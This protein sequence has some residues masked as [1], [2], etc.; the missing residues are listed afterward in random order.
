[1]RS[2]S[3]L[4][5]VFLLV[6]IFF[7]T[8][9]SGDSQNTPQAPTE[10][11]NKPTQTPQAITDPT[12]TSRPE[13]PAT[14]TRLPEPSATPQPTDDQF[15]IKHQNS[16]QIARLAVFGGPAVGKISAATWSE[17]GSWLYVTGS[18]GGAIHEAGTLELLRILPD[19]EYFSFLNDGGTYVFASSG[20]LNF[21]DTSSGENQ[22]EIDLPNFEGELSLVSPLGNFI[23]TRKLPNQ[24]AIWDL[25]GS[26][27]VQEVDLGEFL[28]MDV[29]QLVS[30][31]FSQDGAHLFVATNAGGVYRLEVASGAVERLY[32]AAFVP[33]P[34]RV[35]NTPAECFSP[36]ANGRSLVMLCARYTPSSDASTI[37][38]TYYTLKWIDLNKGESRETAFETRNSLDD[39][40]LSPDGSSLY[41]QG[42][43]EFKLLSNNADGIEITTQPDCLA[44]SVD[45]F[46]IGPTSSGQAAVV[47]SYERGE[48]F[49]CDIDSGERGPALEFDPLSSVAMGIHGEAY[50]AAIGRCSG[51]VELWYPSGNQIANTF[52]AHEGCITDLQF[53]RDGKFL[54][55]GGEDGLVHLWDVETPGAA[56]QFTYSHGEPVKDLVLNHAGKQ[57]ASTSRR[58]LQMWDAENE[59]QIFSKELE[60]GNNVTFGRS[61]WLVVSDGSW[62]D[63]YEREEMYTSHFIDS[64]HLLVDPGSN[65]ITALSPEN[66]WIGF[67]DIDSGALIYSF[68]VRSPDIQAITMSLDGCLLIGVGE[69]EKINVWSLDPFADAA[70][71]ETGVDRHNQV[72]SAGISPDGH[73][74]AVGTEDGSIQL[75]GVP[76]ALEAQPGPTSLQEFCTRLSPPAATATSIPSSTPTATMAPSTATPAAFTRNLYLIQPNLQGADVLALQERLLELGYDQVGI[77][78]GIFGALTDKA[79]RE[80]QEDSGLAVDGVVGPMT[81]EL[82]FGAD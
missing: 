42:I 10:F 58:Q 43:G 68:D 71:I 16:A 70:S 7:I 79:V 23:A 48:L 3:F 67:F 66:D 1:M 33:D 2:A 53:S 81:W 26:Q 57:L 14:P 20:V 22:N 44:H 54:A 78:D 45:P 77:P 34:L 39:P 76:G 61:S 32:R 55:T 21:I 4:T 37:A 11:D 69:D 72:A 29:E 51:R 41:L 59:V 24:V 28:E 6:L 15:L 27:L 64:G 49:L 17:N 73:L 35:S 36:T 18:E 63:W 38:S 9:C 80:F 12:T 5:R 56:A 65:F 25:E 46:A 40:S 8:G 47:N 74:L 19:P 60:Q 82:L 62:I 13:I 75:W 52:Q 31:S 50:L 30:Q